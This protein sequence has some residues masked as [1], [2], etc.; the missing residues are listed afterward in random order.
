MYD[1]AIIGLGPAGLEA[2]QI[3][4]KNG[5]KVIA[6]EKK[7][8]G[9]TC[10]NVGCIPTK[11]I[12][13]SSE[14][15]SFLNKLSDIG[16]SI[17]DGYSYDWQKILERKNN[18]VS[19][20]NKSLDLLLSKKITIIKADAQIQISNNSIQIKAE[21]YLYQA[22]NVIIA[23]GSKSIELSNLKYDNDFVLSSDDL[24]NLNQL[25]KSI[26]IIGSGAIGLEWAKILSD[27]DVEVKIIEKASNLAPI[28]DID[29]QKRIERVLKL[30]K[31]Q[32]FKDDFIKDVIGK[33]IILNSNT[34]FEVEK[35]LCAVGRKPIL[36]RIILN[37]AD[38]ELELNSDYSCQFEN[39]YVVGDANKESMLAH[40]ASYQAKQI[41][42]K[43][44]FN[45]K[46]IKKPSPSVIYITPEIASIGVREQDIKDDNAYKI[47]KIL[48]G[49][50]AKSWCDNANDGLV[51]I[52]IKDDF[53][54][55]AHIVSK[56]ASSLI[57]IFNILIDKKIPVSEIEDIIFPHPSLAEVVL[58]VLKND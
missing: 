53:I 17:Q 10:L 41:L 44:L 31:I 26:A 43:I 38:V 55:G 52:I 42:N 8:L 5:L 19:K 24:F 13:H 27:F 14:V 1:L 54:V 40:S 25:P 15:Y 4:I 12:L 7:D 28:M 33:K 39:I 23:T 29:I 16:I 57:S 36:P 2:A 35:I 56:D 6:F 21:D 20:F 30:N 45:K 51:K 32:F 22:K 58:E 48:I 47:K 18:I 11:A 49:A 3:A 50:L 37:E 46:I 9:G 34:E